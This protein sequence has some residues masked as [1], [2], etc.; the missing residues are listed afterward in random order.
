MTTTPK[1]LTLVLKHA[2]YDVMETGEK[3]FEYREPTDWIKK[4]LYNKDGTERHYDLI[5]FTRGYVSQP[6]FIAEYLGFTIAD[7]SFFK[8]YSNGL[9]VDVM[10][11]DFIIQVGEIISKI[12]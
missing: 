1:V 6:S 12:E 7:D 5:K 11:G 3:K 9:L 8:A 10:Q 4:R 2:P